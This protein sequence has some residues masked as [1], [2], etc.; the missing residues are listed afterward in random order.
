MGLGAVALFSGCVVPVK[1]SPAASVT[2]AQ[3]PPVLD[4]GELANFAVLAGHAYDSEAGIKAAYGAENV[5]VRP[6]PASDGQYFIVVNTR[7]KTQMI[8]VRG[9]ANETNAYVDID[10]IKVPDPALGIFV[11]RGFMAATDQLHADAVPYLKKDYKTSITGHS[12]GGAVA[13][14]LMLRL[15]E[16]GFIVDKVVTFGQPKVTNAA[17]AEKYRNA[18][19][20]R[21]INDQDIVPQTP[22]S[23]IVYDLSGPYVHFGPEIDL[24]AGKQYSYSLVNRPKAYLTGD[25]WKTLNLE[26][27][28]DHQIKAYTDRLNALKSQ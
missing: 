3:K 24:G 22:P 8:S 16:D 4:F 7:D 13:C 9:T 10:S 19:I 25:N 17:G 14:L 15:I 5:I 28:E 27:A 23:D 21:I 20:L 26:D 2:P 12:L 18:P 1:D 6:I 11:H